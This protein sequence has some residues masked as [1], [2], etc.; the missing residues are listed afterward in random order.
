VHSVPRFPRDQAGTEPYTG[1]T[2]NGRINGQSFL[3]LSL[4]IDHMKGAMS[5]LYL[6]HPFI[7]Q[8]GGFSDD[9]RKLLGDNTDALLGEREASEKTSQANTVMLN[10]TNGTLFTSFMKSKHWGKDLYDDLVSQA[11]NSDLFVETWNNGRGTLPTF[12]RNPHCVNPEECGLEHDVANVTEVQIDNSIGWV[13]HKD[14]SKWAVT[15]PTAATHTVCIGDINRQH[16][17]RVRGGGTVCVADESL[18]KAFHG[19][20]KAADTCATN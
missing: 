11:L 4:G 17:Q 8:K 18:W 5:Q 15:V 3:C 20:I 13:N 14:H 6:A 9:L 12:C 1:V 2:K 19:M 16:G 10:A 7:Y